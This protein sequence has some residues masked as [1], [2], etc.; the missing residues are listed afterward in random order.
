MPANRTAQSA[1]P[2]LAATVVS[3]TLALSPTLWSLLQQAP[4]LRS[5]ASGYAGGT[6]ARTAGSAVLPV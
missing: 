6:G 1:V 2:A 5:R 3:P 4:S